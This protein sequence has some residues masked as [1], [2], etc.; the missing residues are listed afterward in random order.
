MGLTCAEGVA[1]VSVAWEICG[2]GE[3]GLGC[4][5]VESELFFWTV[6]WKGMVA[7]R[8]SDVVG[9]WLFVELYL[10]LLPDGGWMS[11]VFYCGY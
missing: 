3:M 9:I 11:G 8:N 10:K 1:Y 4:D 5:A 2:E 7:L 6:G